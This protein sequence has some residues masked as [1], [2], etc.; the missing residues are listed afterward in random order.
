MDQAIALEAP[1][2]AAQSTTNKF[3]IASIAVTVLGAIIYA[4]ALTGPAIWD[5]HDLLKGMGLGNAQSVWDCFRTP[6]LSHYNRPQTPLC[7]LLN[8]KSADKNPFLYHRTN[9]LLHMLFIGS[10][11]ALLNPA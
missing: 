5:D 8:H 9:L 3:W 7:S 11:F 1:H 4:P 2:S 6:F 10:L